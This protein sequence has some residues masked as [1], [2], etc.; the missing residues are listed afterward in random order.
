M[1]KQICTIL[2][3]VMITASCGNI[4]NVDLQLNH[5][6]ALM[7]KQPDSAKIF[8]ESINPNVIRTAKKQARYALL[9]SQALDKNY[10]DETLSLIHI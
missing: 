2:L 8:L 6:E 1:L 5:A 3:I 9:Y 10:I 4:A 7:S